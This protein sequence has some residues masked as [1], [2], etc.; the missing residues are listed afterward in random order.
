MKSIITSY[1]S[2][3]RLEKALAE[4]SIDAYLRDLELFNKWNIELN[5]EK[6]LNSILKDDI[7]S[8]IQWLSDLGFSARSQARIIS[9][10]KSFFN[11]C[12]LEEIT[13]AN[14]AELIETPRLGLHLPETLSLKEID[15]MLDCIDM[16]KADGH[17]N[18]AI[19]EVLYGC[20]LRVS[21][22]VTLTLSRYHVE[23]G[24][25][26]VIGKGNKERLVPIGSSAMKALKQ[27]I[28]Y[29]RVHFPVVKGHEDYIF[30]NQRG[31]QLSRVYVFTLVK[32][33]SE[34]AGIRKNISPH[35]FRHSF[36]THLV[37]RG[38]DLRAVQELLGHKSITTTEIYTH[39]SREFLKDTVESFHPRNQR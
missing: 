10:T 30:Q 25:I 9:G 31:K 29:S 21:E 27:Y 32:K 4:N 12:Y 38:A 6:K 13:I 11:F 1:I 23:E 35:T 16:S 18:N 8:F 5:G 14:P 37:E 36:A 20:G 26:R 39:L 3:L 19:I 2:F 34:L 7:H 24:F 33:L 15:A 22:L 17:R 28:A